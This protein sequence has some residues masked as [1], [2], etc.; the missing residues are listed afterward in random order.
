MGGGILTKSSDNNKVEGKRRQG[1]LRMQWEDC[2]K[3]QW[4]ENGEQQQSWRLVI[5]IAAREK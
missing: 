2:V 4:E 1:R 5:E 3:R